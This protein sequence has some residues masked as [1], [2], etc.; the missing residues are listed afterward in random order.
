MTPFFRVLGRIESPTSSINKR[1]YLLDK[2]S[3][4]PNTLFRQS[5][6]WFVTLGLI[7]KTAIT[8]VLKFQPGDQD[9][10]ALGKQEKNRL[11]A[12]SVILKRQ[13]SQSQSI[14]DD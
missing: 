6:G 9:D 13:F 7:L 14:H 2:L 8:Q 3:I 11:C 4:E 10:D 1:C 5:A 12:I